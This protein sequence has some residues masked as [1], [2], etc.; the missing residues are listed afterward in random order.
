MARGKAMDDFL[1]LAAQNLVS[2][3][4]L[5]F[6]LGAFA[7]L[8]RSDLAIP[9]QVAKAIALYLMFAIGF[10]G[11]AAVAGSGLSIQLGL[12]AGVGIGLGLVIPLIAYALLVRTTRLE[13]VNAAAIAAHY[14]SV[15]VV[16]F[17]AAGEML[18]AMG[19]A[20]Q[21]WIVA[22]MAVMET[23]AIAAGLFLASRAR[24]NASGT[25]E[26]MISAHLMREVFFN[27]SIVLLM[28]AF[29]IGWATGG[30]GMEAV[31]PFIDAPFKGVLCLF[32][33]DM[34]IVAAS[35]LRATRGLPATLV[36]FGLYMPFVSAT[37]GLGAA[38]LLGL[39]AATG[40][41]FI[42]LCASASYIA[43][44]AAMR[45]ALPE[46]NPAYYVTVSLA[47]TFPMNLVIGIPVYEALASQFL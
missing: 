14:G 38:I 46:A 27:G 11:G 15:S 10:K 30:K 9:E 21:G 43:V 19:A 25:R 32:L 6:A 8:V 2:P 23:P 12:T 18:K 41:L 24:T 3:M 33:L 20:P 13:R 29:A 5:F 44:P 28:G 36:A 26:T 1:V 37:L 39:D 42:T 47:V 45:L 31:A 16:T 35:R 22:V 7:A 17:V 34:G 4:V 40:A